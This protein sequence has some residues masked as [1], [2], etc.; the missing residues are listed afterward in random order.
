MSEYINWLQTGVD[1]LGLWFVVFFLALENVPIIGFVAPGVTVLVLSGF[2]YSTIVENIWLLYLV[3]GVT[4]LLA[5][6]F[7][8]WLGYLCANK[9]Q[10]VT[11][12]VLRGPNIQKL[13]LNQPRYGLIGYQ[14]IPYFRMFLPIAL[15]AYGF[16]PKKWLL[17]SLLAT[18]LYTAVFLSIGFIGAITMT[19]LSDVDKITLSTNR[20]LAVGAFVYL[21]VLYVR[22]KTLKKT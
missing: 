5:D 15:G 11:K 21:L 16:S 14:F 2:F 10:W 19:S 7:W 9:V 12:L 3:T 4:I 6:N 1:Q 17:I 13:L 8:F 22:Y 20:I 18:T